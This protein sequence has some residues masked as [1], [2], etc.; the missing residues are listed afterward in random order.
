MRWNDVFATAVPMDEGGAAR[1]SAQSRS[2]CSLQQ[3]LRFIPHGGAH[4][5]RLRMHPSGSDV[6]GGSQQTTPMSTIAADLPFYRPPGHKNL[7]QTYEISQRIAELEAIGGSNSQ[8][9]RQSLV[10]HVVVPTSAPPPQR[11]PE[12]DLDCFSPIEIEGLADV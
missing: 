8:N 5:R 4:Q 9:W 10:A 7:P 6:P 3:M 2:R 12:I 11:T 1:P